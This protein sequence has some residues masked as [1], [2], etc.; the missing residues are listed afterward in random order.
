M[1]RLQVMGLA[2]I[3]IFILLCSS[4]G[5]TAEDSAK[6]DSTTHKLYT[7]DVDQDGDG[8]DDQTDILQ[9]AKEY[10]ASKPKYQSKYY[11]G[12][13]PD[14]GYGVCT[15]VVGYALKHAGYDLRKLV[16][17][18]IKK[19]AAEYGIE[20]AD[21]NIDFRRVPNLNVYFSHK[22]IKL[23]IEVD[24]TDAWQ[25]G[26]IVV[27]ER[28]IGIVADKWNKRGVPYVIHHVSSHQKNYVQDILEKPHS[29]GKLVGHYRIS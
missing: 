11:E 3:L 8:V 2:F 15:D 21:D 9:N 17:Q 23:T 10:I 28:H 7:S 13:Y 16:D 26:D 6:K 12:G 27:Y 25:P 20:K 19:D 4:C 5:Q 18:D 29:Y 22:A 14:D 1:R 24:D